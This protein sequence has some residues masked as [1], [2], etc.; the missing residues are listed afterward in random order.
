MGVIPSPIEQTWPE[1]IRDRIGAIIYDELYQQNAIN[2]TDDLSASVWVDRV[3]PF[4]HSDIRHGAV[5]VVYA[6]TDFTADSQL[7]SDGTCIYEIYFYFA[8]KTT[9]D[10]DGDK[11][12]KFK[13]ARLTG[14]VNRILMDSRYKTLG[15]AMPSIANRRVKSIKISD[16]INS[17]DASSSV[18]AQM[19][20]EVRAIDNVDPV[21]V[22]DLDSYST[23]AVLNESAEGYLYGEARLG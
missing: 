15:F 11:L 19:I 7:T 22:R 9:A 14:V 23:Q 1:K 12:A 3:V 5:N 16:P 13:I 17:Q 20:F 6:G 18:V 4:S 21:S 2:Y 8:A 10:G